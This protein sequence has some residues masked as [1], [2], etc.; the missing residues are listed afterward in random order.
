M[1]RGRKHWGCLPPWVFFPSCVF[2]GRRGFPPTLHPRTHFHV[3]HSFHHSSFPRLCSILHTAPPRII[4]MEDEALVIVLFLTITFY[5]IGFVFSTMWILTRDY[6]PRWVPSLFDTE[7]CCAPFR[8]LIYFWPA[9]LWP[10]FLLYVF[11]LFTA[12]K[13]LHATTCCGKDMAASRRRKSFIKRLPRPWPADQAAL[14][15]DEFELASRTPRSLSKV[16]VP[17]PMYRSRQ[18]SVWSIFPRSNRSLSRTYSAGDLPSPELKRASGVNSDPLPETRDGSPAARSCP[19]KP[20]GL[21]H[22]MLAESPPSIDGC[23]GDLEAQH[24]V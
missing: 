1:F 5:I 22:S 15:V 11:L 7:A 20:S 24:Q 21:C 2:S 3:E 4:N 18:N 6:D 8:P 10:M 16:T 9:I 17:P 13:V 14:P 19:R 23:A 12:D